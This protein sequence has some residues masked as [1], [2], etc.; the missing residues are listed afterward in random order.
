MG[1]GAS[2]GSDTYRGMRL[3]VFPQRQNRPASDARCGA[4]FGGSRQA[5]RTDVATREIVAYGASCSSRGCWAAANKHEVHAGSVRC[6]LLARVLSW[7]LLAPERR[8]PT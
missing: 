7:S 5:P 1:L 6:P 3:Y 8:A 4:C 2:A